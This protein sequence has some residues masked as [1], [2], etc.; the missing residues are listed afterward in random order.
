MVTL[1]LH[2]ILWAKPEIE[3]TSSRVLVDTTH[4]ATTVTPSMY[5]H[6]VGIRNLENGTEREREKGRNREMER[7]TFLRLQQQQIIDPGFT[8]RPSAN[9]PN[10][11]SFLALRLKELPCVLKICLK[12]WYFYKRIL[13]P[14]VLATHHGPSWFPPDPQAAQ[15]GGKGKQKDWQGQKKLWGSGAV[16]PLS[17]SAPFNLALKRQVTGEEVLSLVTSFPKKCETGWSEE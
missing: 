14:A 10:S 17:H 8:A 9:K 6:K 11:H 1:D 16:P 15:T 4:W 13:F 12:P 3:L 5:F 2:W 7:Q